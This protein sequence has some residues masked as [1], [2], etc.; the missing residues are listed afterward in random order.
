[1]SERI[2]SAVNWTWLPRVMI[3]IGVVLRVAHYAVNRS[4]WLDE[5]A[6]ALNI[7]NRSWEQLWL[8]LDYNQG[9][10]IGFLLIEKLAVQLLGNN[11]FALRLVPLLSGVAVLVLFYAIAKR[12]VRASTALIGLGLV[13]V[14]SQLIY[15]SAEVKQYSSDAAIGLLLIGIVL[16]AEQKPTSIWR[17]ILR[18]LSGAAAMWF[19]H[20]AVFV[21]AGL[22]TGLL[23]FRWR[24]HDKR[25]IGTLVL[26]GLMW[27]ISFGILYVVSLASLSRNSV[28]N[29][30][31]KSGFMPLAVTQWRWYLDT[32]LGMFDNPVGLP[33][34]GLAAVCF[35]A[36]A[37]ALWRNDRKLLALLMLPLLATLAASAVRLH[38]F[39]GR[40]ILFLVPLIA[41]VI[42]EG[43]MQLH[44]LTRNQFAVV[45]VA[46]IVLLFA[47]PV[48]NAVE[49]LAQPPLGEDIRPAVSY[50]RQHWQAGDKLYVYYG[51]RP[52]FMYYGPQFGFG[53]NDVIPGEAGR[54]DWNQ[55]W[56]EIDRLRGSP[57]VWLLFSHVWQSSGVD[58]EKFFLFR[59]N[60]LGQQLDAQQSAGAAAYLYD[61]S[62]K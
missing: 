34:A 47:Q 45:G 5:S 1:M 14:S 38:P 22:G 8:P 60:R 42:A 23:V 24:A 11:E 55:Y 27:G 25:A 21:L 49:N 17:A 40:L 43:V 7:A 31:W 57:R 54:N 26:S 16:Y 37:A 2:R 32:F 35:V 18:G 56:G 44:T 33:L 50:I 3:L 4:L 13:V 28:L 20:P 39:S 15:Y 6:L 59:L 53:D 51:A 9:A 52:A 12:S 62:S 30:Y 46:V 10:P 58:E 19:S 61:L 41:I 48:I 29:N 36:G